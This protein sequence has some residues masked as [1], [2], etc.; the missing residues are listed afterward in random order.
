MGPLPQV[1]KQVKFL[2]VAIDYF[3]KWIEAE[4][5]ATITE[6]KVQNFVWKN[7]V[8]RFRIPQM[9]ILD[10]DCQLDSQGFKSFCSSLVIKNKYSFLGNPQ[11]NGQ[12]EVTNRTLLKII[13]ARLVGAKGAWLEELPSVLWAYRTTAR[14]PTRETPFDLTY[15]TEA[16]IPVEIGLTGLRKDFFNEHNNDDQLKL[17]LDYLDEVRDQA[18]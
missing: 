16:V 11:A 2:L 4:V 13:K 14:T 18:S 5:L 15:G 3:K 7:I 8:W 9:I 6:A 17:N 12:I 10:N 1:K